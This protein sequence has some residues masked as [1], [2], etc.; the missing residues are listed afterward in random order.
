MRNEIYYSFAGRLFPR[1]NR[2]ED[3]GTARAFSTV[4]EVIGGRI[5][6]GFEYAP[7]QGHTIA[8]SDLESSTPKRRGVSSI[9][10]IKKLLN[11]I[12]LDSS[13][14]VFIFMTYNVSESSFS[15]G[16]ACEYTPDVRLRIAASAIYQ[17]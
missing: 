16:Y 12:G 13:N 8:V 15:L 11:I 7:N 5:D 14:G 2:S 3:I 9:N 6:S 1:G 10:V 17:L 4:T